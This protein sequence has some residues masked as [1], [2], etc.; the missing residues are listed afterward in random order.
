[1]ASTWDG[2]ASIRA[3]AS[4]RSPV[5]AETDAILIGRGDAIWRVVVST[6]EID[7]YGFQL[8]LRSDVDVGD[9]LISPAM[10]SCSC[11]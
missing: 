1:M 11:G 4:W 3:R 8:L 9:E 2:P 10:W 6:D 7:I 5:H